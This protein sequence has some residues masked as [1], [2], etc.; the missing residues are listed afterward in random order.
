MQSY[1]H[2]TIENKWKDIWFKNN[3][4]KAIDFSHKPKKYILAEFPYPSGKALHAGHMMRFTLPDVYARFQRLKGFN[5]MFPMGWDAFGL[6]AE[7]FAVK[8]GIN[9]TITTKEIVISYCDSLLR[10]GYSIDTDREIN[11]TDPKYY[12]WTQW[13]FLKFFKEGLAE[14]KEMPIWWCQNLKTVLSDE[15]VL[16]DKDGNKI[17]ERGEQPVERKMLK[18]WVLKILAYADRLIDGLKKVDFPDSI[19]NMQINWIDRKEG[20]NISYRVD[21]TDEVI[22]VFTTRPDTNFG[23][24]FIVLAPEHELA[25]S[26]STKDNY[27]AVKSYIETAKRKSDLERIADTKDKTGVFTG[28]YV[29]NDLNGKKLPVY[30]SDYVLVGFGTGAVVG[31]P[32]HDK[33]D[34]LFAQ[35][36]QIPIV[37]VVVGSDGDTS[38]ITKLDQV[39][40]KDGTMVNSD[41]LN[42]MDI[43]KATTEIMNYLEKKGWGERTIIYRLRDWVFSRQR[44]W[45][46][47]IPVLHYEDGHI[48]PICDIDNPED[49]KANLPLQLPEQEDFSPS[50]DGSSPLDKNIAWVNVV[51]VK[52]RPA[53]RET[54]TMPNWAGSC[55]YY[56]RYCDPHN[57]TAFADFEKMKYWLPVD[58]YFG[59]AEH[60]T[61]HLL[62][63]RFWH[64]FLFDHKLVPTE[65]PYQWRL[66]GGLLLGVDGKKMSKSKGNVVEPTEIIKIYG[67]D[68]L[69]MAICFLGPYEDTYPWNENGL[70]A[71]AKVVSTIFALSDRVV[72]GYEDAPEITGKFAKT[73]ENISRM[74]E[75]LKMN[76]VVSEIMIF[77]NA[78]KN[79]HK[80]SKTLWKNFLITIAPIAPFIAEELWQ[81]VND[82][83]EWKDKNSVHLQNWP[84]LE[85][86]TSVDEE[87]TLPIQVNGKVRSQINVPKNI[88]ED[89]LKEMVIK[90]TRIM[91]YL[92]GKEF[93]KFI[94]VRGKIVSLVV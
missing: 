10:M 60:T 28:A 91:P 43:H 48:E 42:D 65:E 70:K 51:D 46:E 71:T 59:G 12:K 44:Y 82:Y 45:G 92:E 62:Y 33:Q 3:V 57:D 53:K 6:P 50:D 58:R 4:F 86:N 9:P 19:K 16:T 29:I 14:Y 74:Y 68:A 39:Q 69:R 8:T 73:H 81:K 18:Q 30:I 52:G 79:E 17:S 85:K 36:Y 23:A 31:V 49:V 72:D 13:I 75:E 27:E 20:I 41:F 7:L 63:S 61:L 56:L 90:D 32:A 64:Q 21:G 22:K 93:K 89:M 87:I 78:I 77:I 55:W 15:E 94:Y 83:S 54:N 34:F 88:T 26:I 47:P 2:E 24:T 38:E 5:V 76:T 35:K 1:D 84:E 67:A 40:E 37:R 11:T 80:I 25:L 66:N